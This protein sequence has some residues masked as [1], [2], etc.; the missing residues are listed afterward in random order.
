MQSAQGGAAGHRHG[1]SLLKT[2]PVGQRDDE[3]VGA[4]HG[5][6]RPDPALGLHHAHVGDPITDLE[7]TDRG[8]DPLYRPRALDTDRVGVVH[9]T[10]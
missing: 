10:G 6:L 3:G 5:I 7:A 4:H 2:Q 9:L 1:G 8:P